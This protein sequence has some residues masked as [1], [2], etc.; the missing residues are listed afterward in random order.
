MNYKDKIGESVYTIRDNN[1][2]RDTIIEGCEIVSLNRGDVNHGKL[3]PEKIQYKLSS[4]NEWVSLD[5][6]FFTKE[7]LIKSLP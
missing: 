1:I 5:K 7:D 2:I 3:L 6:I 4:K